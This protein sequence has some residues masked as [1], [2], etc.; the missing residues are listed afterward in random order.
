[1]PYAN[2]TNLG[3]NLHKLNKKP[4]SAPAVAE[5]METL[6]SY[7]QPLDLSA[8]IVEKAT[9][10]QQCAYPNLPQIANQHHSRHQVWIV[11]KDLKNVREY[12]KWKSPMLRKLT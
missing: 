3:I 11:V 12:M 5:S 8:P 6:E 1:M 7:V 10:R 4:N 9:I 2:L